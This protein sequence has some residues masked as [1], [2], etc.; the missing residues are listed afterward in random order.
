MWNLTQTCLIIKFHTFSITKKS[1]YSF[2]LLGVLGA[3]Q[4]TPKADVAREHTRNV[5]KCDT[6]VTVAVKFSHEP[7][8]VQYSTEQTKEQ[9]VTS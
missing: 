4:L 8:S 3:E 6:S 1:K 7:S 2:T 5:P 9:W